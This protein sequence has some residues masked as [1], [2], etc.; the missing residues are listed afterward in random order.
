MPAPK[1]KPSRRAPLFPI[2]FTPADLKLIARLATKT[3]SLSTADVVRR[4]LRALAEK[5]GLK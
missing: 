5:E 2:R 4:G 3:G 1:S